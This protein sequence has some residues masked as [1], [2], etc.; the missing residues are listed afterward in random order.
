M[1]RLDRAERIT[2][3]DCKQDWTSCMYCNAIC[4]NGGNLI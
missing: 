2:F 1:A 3:G 4:S